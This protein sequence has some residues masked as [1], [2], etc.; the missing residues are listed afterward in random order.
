MLYG[1]HKNNNDNNENKIR[2]KNDDNNTI[3]TVIIG[4]ITIIMRKIMITTNQES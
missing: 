2:I 3:T 4:K 1:N